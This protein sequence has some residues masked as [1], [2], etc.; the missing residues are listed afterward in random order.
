MTLT[1]DAKDRRLI[2]ELDRNARASFTELARLAGVS[3]QVARYR[4]NRLERLGAIGA[5]FAI[6]DISRLGFTIRKSFIKLHGASEEQEAALVA[7]LKR[8]PNVVWLVSCDGQ[9][10]IAFGMWAANIDEYSAQLT[11]VDRRFGHLFL[12]N[13]IAPIVR[14]QYFCRD[15]LLGKE[16]GTEQD[17]T[18]GAIPKESGVDEADW[19]ILECLGANAR[20]PLS[21]MAARA[22]IS[23][24]ATGK[25]LRRLERTR[26]I[27]NYILVLNNSV[28]G[29]LHYKVFVKLRSVTNN[30]YRSLVEFCRLHPNIFYIV[31]TFGVWDF[32]IDLEVRDA[33]QFRSVMRELKKS[34][35]SIISDYS[36]ITVYDI[37]KYN[38]CPGRRRALQ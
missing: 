8:N 24:D 6:I 18:I 26:V 14:G 13:Q 27:Q 17:L 29:Q 10:D 22:G 23:P 1:L 35:S 37:H 25:R 30:K 38:F 34:F 15:Y 5:Y 2:Y 31:K 33:Q 9:F 28:L 16:A 21:E 12:Q 3:K 7:W 4:L 11:E 19:K 32:E 36:Y 20:T